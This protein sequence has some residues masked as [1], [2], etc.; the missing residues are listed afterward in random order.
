MGSIL[1]TLILLIF[2]KDYLFITIDFFLQR[3]CDFLATFAL[4]M[5]IIEKNNITTN[6]PFLSYNEPR[7]ILLLSLFISVFIRVISSTWPYIKTNNILISQLT[8]ATMKT[9]V[10]LGII[11]LLE[12]YKFN[13][14]YILINWILLIAAIIPFVIFNL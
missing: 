7:S 4:I 8:L 6:D 3:L 10:G 1:I 9:Y 14:Y 11:T 13:H 12:N 5:M 2:N